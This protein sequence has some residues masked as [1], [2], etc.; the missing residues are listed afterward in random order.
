MSVFEHL[1]QDDISIRRL[2]ASAANG[3]KTYAPARALPPAIIKGRLDFTRKTITKADGTEYVSEAVLRTSDAIATGDL[4]IHQ[5]REWA[6][7]AV[8]EKRAL[9]QGVDHREARL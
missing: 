6:V 1:M 2:I 5:G 3:T 8:S 7:Q 4:V 9:F